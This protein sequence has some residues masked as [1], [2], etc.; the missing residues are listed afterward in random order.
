VRGERGHGLPQTPEH[1]AARQVAERVV[2][3]DESFV[4]VRVLGV[5]ADGDERPLAVEDAQDVVA[6]DAVEVRGERAARRVEVPAVAHQDHEDFLRHVL[7]HRLRAAHLQREAVD[8]ALPPPVERDESLLVS[9][10]HTP[11]QFRV[12]GGLGN[13]HPRLAARSAPA[14]TTDSRARP[15]KF[16]KTAGEKFFRPNAR[17]KAGK[18]A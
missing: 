14:D 15:E 3:R 17:K 5:V 18:M 2:V 7:G 4:H 16:Q 11:Q 13:C 10:Q 12:S 8:R 6:R 1:L 9:G